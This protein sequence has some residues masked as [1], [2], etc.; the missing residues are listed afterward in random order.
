MAVA[1][2]CFQGTKPLF[3]KFNQIHILREADSE[4]VGG[5]PKLLP[6]GQLG[7]ESASHIQ[8]VVLVL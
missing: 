1:G 4:A 8:I 3:K 6:K 2:K 7:S 5:S